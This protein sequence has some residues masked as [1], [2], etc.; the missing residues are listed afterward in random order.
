MYKT[1][2][3]PL[4][5]SLRAEAILPHVEELA[6]RYQ[7]TLVLLQ[8]VDPTTTI[9]DLE[10][11]SSEINRVIVK[12]DV[13]AGTSY[14]TAIQDRLRQKGAE[15]RI[16]V[17]RGS[18]VDGIIGVA[19]RE[20]ADLIAMASHGRTGLARVFFGSVAQGVLNRA[21]QPVLL[22]RSQE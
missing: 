18:A 9:P 8:V 17:E 1:V 6:R 10:G 5:G 22:L 3:V 15:A 14:L 2:L 16:A 20:R 21:K 11:L 7:A 12:E 19:E 4:D 13:D